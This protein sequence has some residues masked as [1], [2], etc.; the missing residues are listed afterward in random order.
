MSANLDAGRRLAWPQHD[1]DGPA[2]VGVVDMDRQEAAR[3]VVGVEQRELPTPM[4]DIAGV[5]DVQGDG[6]GLAF[7]RVHPLVNE[8]IA[9]PDRVLQRKRILQ[10]RQG[11]LRTTIAARIGEPSA[12][13]LEGWIG[14]QKIQIVSVLIAA[15]N[16]E[17]AGADHVVLSQR[18]SVGEEGPG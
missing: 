3:V 10:P 11:R 16:G 18:F 9:Q 12:G 7:I 13:E 5:V 15:G 8:R 14:A 2:S 17:D 1:G 4:H 6:R